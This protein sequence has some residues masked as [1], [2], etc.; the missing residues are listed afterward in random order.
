VKV[1]LRQVEAF[2]TVADERHFGRAAQRL[3]VSRRG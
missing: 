3:H 2:L 1:T